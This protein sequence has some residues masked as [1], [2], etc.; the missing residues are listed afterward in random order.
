MYGTQDLASCQKFSCYRARVCNLLNRGTTSPWECLG[1]VLQTISEQRHAL[2]LVCRIYKWS[3]PSAIFIISIVKARIQMLWLVLGMSENSSEMIFKEINN[4]FV[5]CLEI[6][7]AFLNSTTIGQI[8]TVVLL[9]LA[10]Q[11]KR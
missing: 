4:R 5:L 6:A 1:R 8:Q 11:I 10:L 2:V 3:V 9:L 7:T